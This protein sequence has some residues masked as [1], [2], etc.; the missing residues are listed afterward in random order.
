[1]RTFACL[2]AALMLASCAAQDGHHN[3]NTDADA[4]DVPVDFVPDY[5]TDIGEDGEGGFI[6]DPTTCAEA[7]WSH[8]YVGCDFW[9][10]VLPNYVGKHFDYAVVVSNAGAVEAGVTIERGGSIVAEDV[11]PPS[12]LRKFYLPWVDELKHWTGMCDTVPSTAAPTFVSRRVPGGAYHLTSTRP[13][14]VY[15]FNPIEY[16]P[17]G[18]PPGKDWSACDCLFGCH[19][20]TNDASLLLPSTAAT[21][22]YRITAPAGQNTEDVTQPGYFSVT[23]FEEGTQVTVWVGHGGQVV[24]GDDI[25]DTAAGHVFEFEIGRGEVVRIVGTPTTDLSGSLINATAPVQVLSG[26]PCHYMPDEYGACDHMEE[27]VF[28]AETLGDHYFVAVP[29]NSRGVPIGHVVRL[30]GN[31]DGT[32][33]E[34]PSGPPPGAPTTIDAGRVYDLGNVD[35]SFE[36]SG[37]H[38]FAVTSFLLGSSLSDPGHPI[39]Y[40][41]DPAQ[42]NVV[43]V[44]QYR[45]KYVFLAPDDYDVAYAD[46]V[47]P[48]DAYVMID[49]GEMTAT[50]TPISS[51]YGVARVELGLGI[52]GAHVLESD[53]PVSL[54]VMGYGFATSYHY[55]GGLNLS[56]IS[57][58]PII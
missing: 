58:P 53:Q 19:S 42:S 47:M 37:N 23:G 57:E 49:G 27:S 29:T 36:V 54:Q 46:I 1:M 35:T 40:L 55:P 21:G 33:L 38:E 44:A 39:N 50:A 2:S 13:V 56:E 51:G 24:G 6:E 16:G 31:V 17:E 41:G 22:N 10:T 3:P 45:R 48:L 11:V 30:Y 14:T 28:P 43:C 12:G 26:A 4:G 20:Y 7:A 9:P 52:D 32:A 18:G 15:Q 5:P 25:P 8:S 34:Y